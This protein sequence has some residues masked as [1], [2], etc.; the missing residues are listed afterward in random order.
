MDEVGREV[1]VLG[2]HDQINGRVGWLRAT[3]MPAEVKKI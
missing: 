2:E 1:R 3:R